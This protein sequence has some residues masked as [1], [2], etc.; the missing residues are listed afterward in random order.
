MRD[1]QKNKWLLAVV[2]RVLTFDGEITRGKFSDFTKMSDFCK[3]R[4]SSE[5]EHVKQLLVRLNPASSALQ[6]MTYDSFVREAVLFAAAGDQWKHI[7]SNWN[8]G[9]LGK[10]GYCIDEDEK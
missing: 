7:K 10:H 2:H 8:Q 4:Y 3:G 5:F 6:D 1:A 9:P